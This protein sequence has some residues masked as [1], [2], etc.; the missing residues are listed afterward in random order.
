MSQLLNVCEEKCG[1]T[2]QA[3]VGA[4]KLEESLLPAVGGSRWQ[5]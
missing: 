4:G 2:I 1:K 5:G 3:G